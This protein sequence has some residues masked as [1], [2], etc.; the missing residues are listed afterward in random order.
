MLQRARWGTGAGVCLL[1]PPRA[2]SLHTSVHPL[3]SLSLFRPLLVAVRGCE[4][5]RGKREDMRLAA[6]RSPSQRAQTLSIGYNSLFLESFV[7][8]FEMMKSLIMRQVG[9]RSAA[10]FAQPQKMSLALA[11]SFATYYMDSHEYIIVSKREKYGTTPL[12]LY[13]YLTSIAS[14]TGQR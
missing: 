14:W 1:L 2:L 11:R 7:C 4:I 5:R 10:R 3:S 8:S 9:L 12:D 13:I 6:S